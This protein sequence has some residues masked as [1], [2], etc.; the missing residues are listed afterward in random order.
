MFVLFI[1]LIIYTLFLLICTMTNENDISAQCMIP[2]LMYLN[3]TI[4][5]LDFEFC[6][7]NENQKLLLMA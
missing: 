7:T 6:S 2:C 4:T 5:Y 3:L 1:Y